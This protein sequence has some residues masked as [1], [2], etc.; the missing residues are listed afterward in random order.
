MR[1]CVKFGR[2]LLRDVAYLVCEFRCLIISMHMFFLQFRAACMLIACMQGAAWEACT[3]LI[4]LFYII[5]YSILYYIFVQITTYLS[6][7]LSYLYAMIWYTII[8][9]SDSDL[10]TFLQQIEHRKR[11]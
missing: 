8:I 3:Y 1:V 9:L 7:Y 5:L 11:M 2:P 6:Y 4:L 10:R